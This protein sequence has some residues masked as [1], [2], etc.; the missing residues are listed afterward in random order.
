[1]G[2]STDDQRLERPSA[3]KL[4]VEVARSFDPLVWLAMLFM[5]MAMTVAP[6]VG[7]FYGGLESWATG[8]GLTITGTE[9][10]A[11]GLMGGLMM[12]G[13]M[14]LVLVMTTWMRDQ[15]GERPSSEVAQG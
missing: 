12:A 7:L 2:N 3:R 14:S 6:T 13:A 4:V 1:M 9:A 15:L 10:L 11:V 5:T 8:G